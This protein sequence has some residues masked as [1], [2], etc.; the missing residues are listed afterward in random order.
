MDTPKTSD[1]LRKKLWECYTA[2]STD[3]IFLNSSDPM[4][5]VLDRNGTK[6][7]EHYEAASLLGITTLI[8][9]GGSILYVGGHGDGKTSL[10]KAFGVMLAGVPE[11]EIEEHVLRL[12]PEQ[13]EEKI[14]ARPD[15]AKLFDRNNPQEVPI[16][17]KWTTCNFKV[18]DEFNR[19]SPEVMNLF[20][21]GIEEGVWRYA[22]HVFNVPDQRIIG[23]INPFGEGT[24]EID[25][26]MYDR[27]S[28]SCPVEPA[29]IADLA[30]IGGRRDVVLYG[31]GLRNL[32][33]FE[34]LKQA[35]QESDKISIDPDAMLQMNYF[36]KELSLCARAGGD[37]ARSKMKP[38][39]GLCNKCHY[40]TDIKTSA[41]AMKNPCQLTDAHVSTRTHEKMMRA[42]KRLAWMLEQP[43]VTIEI[44]GA[45]APYALYHRI[46]PNDQV[47]TKDPYNGNVMKMLTDAWKISQSKLNQRLEA[48]KHYLSLLRG[49]GSPQDIE[50]MR[51]MDDLIVVHDMLPYVQ[52]MQSELYRGMVKRVLTAKPTE[53][54]KLESEYRELKYRQLPLGAQHQIE[55]TL[56]ER[57]RET[58]RV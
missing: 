42:S 32:M 5:I 1:E 26:A 20:F 35:T 7:S 46:K 10:A 47:L 6:S 48:E 23:T 2:L 19:A 56:R 51:Q 57:Y 22:D 24:F 14:V 21:S 44:A 13:T 30:E 8:T 31:R 28:L 53:L 27:F 38:S 39:D 55:A 4:E 17:R 58:R 33:T 54:G 15:M 36:Q 52:G 40:S 45:I 25:P 41:A 16:P 43:S 37:K 9:P 29:S 50:R 12:N 49:Q 34:D 18:I 3:I 11:S